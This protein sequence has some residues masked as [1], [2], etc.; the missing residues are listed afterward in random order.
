MGNIVFLKS[1][2]PSLLYKGGSTPFSSSEGEN[3]TALRCSESL[4]SKDGKQSGLY[5]LVLDGIAGERLFTINKLQFT[6]YSLL[7]TLNY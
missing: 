6:V 1:S 7:L 5:Q 4:S 3:I 2:S